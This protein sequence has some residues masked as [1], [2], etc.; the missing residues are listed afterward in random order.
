MAMCELLHHILLVVEMFGLETCASLEAVQMVSNLQSLGVPV[1]LSTTPATVSS[2]IGIF[3]IPALAI[4][5]DRK[6]SSR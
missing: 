2:I 6:A 1:Q 3:L 4:F 5:M